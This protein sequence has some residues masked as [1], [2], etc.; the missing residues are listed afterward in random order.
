MY[1][2][3][4]LF[5]SVLLLQ[6]DITLYSIK[7]KTLDKLLRL[8][9]GWMLEVFTVVTPSSIC[10]KIWVQNLSKIVAEAHIKLSKQ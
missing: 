6:I 2:I 7:K 9:R 10:R 3:W 1:L 5:Y 4:T 8:R